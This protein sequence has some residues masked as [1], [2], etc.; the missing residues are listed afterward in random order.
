MIKLEGTIE[1]IIFYNQDNYYTVAKLKPSSGKTVTIVGNLPSLFPGEVLSLEGEWV[2]HKDYGEQFQVAEWERPTPKTLIGIERFLAGGLIKGIG[3]ATAEKIVHKFGL[4]SLDI[5]EN[6]PERLAEIPGISLKKASKIATSLKEHASIQR[7]MV[8]LQGIG[9]SPAYALKI[10]RVYGDQAVNVVS[11]NPYQL[12]DDVFGIG[13]KIADQIAGKLGIEKESP[14]RIRAGI[15][16]LLSE[17]SNEGHVY[18]VEKEFLNRAGQEL[19]VNELQL[20]AEVEELI[21][22]K[23]IFRESF[24]GITVLYSAPF[25]YSEVGTASKIKELLS[26]EL[27]Q[28]P[29]N[30]ETVLQDFSTK[31]RLT[32]APKQKEAVINSLKYGMMVIT[33]GPGTGKTTI[34]KAIIQLFYGAKM[35]V[36]LAAPTGRAAKRLAETTGQEAKTIHRLLGYGNE[37]KNGGRFQHNEKEPLAAEVLIIDEFSMVDLPLFYNLLKAITLGTRLIMVGDVDQLPSV[38]PG[39]VLRDLI[40]SQRIPTVRLDVIFRQAEESLIVSNAHKINRGEFP[41]L[42]TAKD[43]FFIPKEDPEQI[44]QT[45]S[46]LIKNRISKYLKCDPLEDIQVLSPMRRTIT[47]VENLNLNLQAALNPSQPGKVEL[48]VGAN[49]FRVGDKVMQI[50]NDYQRLVFNGD[51]GRIGEIDVEDRSLSVV[52]QDVDGERLIDYE[53]E[54]LDQLV[55]AYAISVHKSQGNEYPVVI[56]PVTTQHFLMLQRNLLYTAVTRA[57]KM[58]V[59]IGTKKAIAIA[60]KNNRIEE[61]H[62]LLGQRIEAALGGSW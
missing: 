13:F 57:K 20:A 52:Y 26:I 39:S 48:K 3:K 58:V 41:Y 35:R 45:I 29:V 7:I 53:T 2:K 8:F 12:A 60:V 55:L 38:G 10:Y 19:G 25:Y 44:V 61:R 47:G 59:I 1:Q 50:K 23:E 54:E 11:E 34:I 62:S 32:L 51:I 4:E 14:Y 37:S 18:A 24:S 9:I 22:Q 40:R 56:I 36:L 17:V 43:F 46:D 21:L 31:N 42:S 33:G 5:I 30:P 28:V 27:R 16:Y 6:A 15:R 49:V